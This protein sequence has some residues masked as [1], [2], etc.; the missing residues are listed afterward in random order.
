MLF[1][2]F[3]LECKYSKFNQTKRY[4]S[5][6]TWLNSVNIWP[7]TIGNRSDR[8]TEKVDSHCRSFWEVSILYEDN[9]WAGIR[10]EKLIRFLSAMSCTFSRVFNT[11]RGHL[12]AFFEWARSVYRVIVST[13]GFTLRHGGAKLCTLDFMRRLCVG[14]IGK[15]FP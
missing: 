15:Y 4:N 12:V 1:N 14:F 3:F 9:E 13:D 2:R 11:P 8:S 6:K 7:S 5:A 10:F